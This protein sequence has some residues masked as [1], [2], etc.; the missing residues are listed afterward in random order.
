MDKC[1]N[2]NNGIQLTLINKMLKNT[3]DLDTLT[4]NTHKTNRKK[5]Y[6]ATTFTHAK[7][8]KYK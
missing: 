6:Y 8:Q 3:K 7:P 1:S 4:T 2:Y 5:L